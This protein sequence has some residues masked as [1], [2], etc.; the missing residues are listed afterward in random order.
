M[1]ESYGEGQM[2]NRKTSASRLSHTYENPIPLEQHWP[3]SL[4]PLSTPSTGIGEQQ[5]GEKRRSV[6]NVKTNI[7]RWKRVSW[8]SREQRRESVGSPGGGRAACRSEEG[9][10]VFFFFFFLGDMI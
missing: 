10:K 4:P 6:C 1:G 3:S 7:K 9:D 8:C 5:H 2:T